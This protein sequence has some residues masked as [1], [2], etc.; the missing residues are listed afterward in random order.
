MAA[1]G[2]NLFLLIL[3]IIEILLLQ[4]GYVRSAQKKKL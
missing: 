1:N 2:L 4:I 3:S